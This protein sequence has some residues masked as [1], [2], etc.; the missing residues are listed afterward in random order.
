MELNDLI[1]P[2][3]LIVVGGLSYVIKYV[4]P[5]IQLRIDD[6]E[7]HKT[8]ALTKDQMTDIL[9][10]NNKLMKEMFKNLVL[11]LELKLKES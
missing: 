4:I 5:K 11:E 2:S 6:L 1:T 8:T 10:N 7:T 9:D 3:L